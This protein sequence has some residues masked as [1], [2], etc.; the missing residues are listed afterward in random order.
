MVTQVAV[1]GRT[2]DKN[3][4][5]VGANR[6][7]YPQDILL[8]A[9]QENRQYT[10]P[11]IFLQKIFRFKSE[12]VKAVE[13]EFHEGHF[14]AEE[15]GQSFFGG[16]ICRLAQVQI[17]IK[18]F[19]VVIQMSCKKLIQNFFAPLV[20]ALEVRQVIKQFPNVNRTCNHCVNAL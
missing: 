10:Q 2:H 12:S 11:Q 6:I 16:V 9:N 4:L 8:V 20:V 17:F 13:E 1:R 3:S 7:H 18:R 15:V 19:G 14:V 5:V